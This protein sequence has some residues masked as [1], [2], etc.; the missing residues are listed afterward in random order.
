MPFRGRG[1]RQIANAGRPRRPMD[2]EC[3][4][5]HQILSAD[6]KACT[7]LIP[8]SQIRERYTDPTLMSTMVWLNMAT[9]AAVGD[10]ETTIGFGIIVVN[11]FSDQE[12]F[13]DS[14]PGPLS[15]CNADWVYLFF[16]TVARVG[17]GE[18]LFSPSGDTH[19]RRS[20][21]KRRLGND[22]GILLVSET[23]VSAARVHAHV[24]CLIKE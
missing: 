4:E 6:S 23:V 15:D 11:A 13:G 21:A 8:P 3:G 16:G 18:T 12:P 22:K 1:G 2:W 9:T 20:Q 14:C 10:F 17:G 24:R 5:H 7:W 19:D